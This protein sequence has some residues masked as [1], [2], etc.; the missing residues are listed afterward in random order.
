MCTCRRTFISS[1]AFS[2]LTPVLQLLCV[3][4][5]DRNKGDRREGGQKSQEAVDGGTCGGTR[6]AAVQMQ[7]IAQADPMHSHLQ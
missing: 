2:I 4:D 7:M 1:V 3:D 5:E 6:P